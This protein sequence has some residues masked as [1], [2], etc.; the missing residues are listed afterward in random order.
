MVHKI[1]TIYIIVMCLIS[2]FQMMIDKKRAIKHRYRISERALLLTAFVGGSYGAFIGMHLF[3]HKTR[4][5][6]FSLG[7]PAMMLF[8]TALLVLLFYFT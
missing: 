8:H 5:K 4:R 1:V 7:I 6:A 2:F 3:R